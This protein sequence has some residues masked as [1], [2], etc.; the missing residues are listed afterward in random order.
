MLKTGDLVVVNPQV[1]TRDDPIEPPF[2]FGW[3]Q[4]FT[5]GTE[6]LAASV[7]RHSTYAEIVPVPLENVFKV[8]EPALQRQGIETTDLAFFT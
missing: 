4:G 8:N 2:M 1:H 5:A 7:W 3:M 6:K